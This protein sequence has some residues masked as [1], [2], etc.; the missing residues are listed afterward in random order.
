MCQEGKRHRGR[1]QEDSTSAWGGGI[2]CT[3][4]ESLGASEMECG[5][6]QETLGAM[7]PG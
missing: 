6:W 1:Q 5:F 7:T 3:K 2:I 4:Q